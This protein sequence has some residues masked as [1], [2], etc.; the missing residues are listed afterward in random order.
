[1]R[2][3]RFFFVPTVR[4]RTSTG[5]MLFEYCFARQIFFFLKIISFSTTGKNLILVLSTVPVFNVRTYVVLL[6][7][8]VLSL[9]RVLYI[10]CNVTS[11][12]GTVQY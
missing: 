5:I 12:T 6:E 2:L 8:I 10:S 4:Y 11:L 7:S 3:I 1:M 9:R